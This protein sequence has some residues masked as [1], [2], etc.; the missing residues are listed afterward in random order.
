MT[1]ASISERASDFGTRSSS[2]VSLSGITRRFGHKWALRG[3]ELDVG[4]GELV[5][6]QGP[7]GG[8]KSTLLRV[9]ATAIAPTGGSGRILGLDLKREASG[10]RQR[11]AMLGSSNGHYEDLSAREN[12]RFAARMLGVR[13]P[14]ERIAVVLTHVGLSQDAD[15]R[16]R[17]FSSGMQRRLALGR[18][19]L[20]EPQ[21][22]LLDEPFNALDADGAVLVNDLIAG[23]RQRGGTAVVVLHDLARLTWTPSVSYTMLRGRLT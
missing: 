3:I 17:S 19:M 15:E 11:T 16:V 5:V 22:L 12:L 20:Q 14:E 1:S 23:V 9:I 10:I 18:T 7:N 8:G 13:Q 6:I 21:L 4:A 2:A